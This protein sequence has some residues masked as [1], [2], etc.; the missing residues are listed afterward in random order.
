MTK[1]YG[2]EGE[3]I[4]QRYTII[5]EGKPINTFYMVRWAGV[6]PATGEAMY[7]DVDGEITN[8]WSGDDKVA[9]DETPIH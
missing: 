5:E 2:E 3:P 1:L 9:L 4:Q 6:N 8:T 7:L